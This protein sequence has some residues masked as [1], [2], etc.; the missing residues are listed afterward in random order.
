[1]CVTILLINHI[2]SGYLPADIFNF[3]SAKLIF[4]FIVIHFIYVNFNYSQRKINLKN[5]F[6]CYACNI[7]ELFVGRYN[8]FMLPRLLF[9]VKFQFV[10]HNLY[11][12]LAPI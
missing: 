1:M 4:T 12:H 3:L 2:I 6:E 5:I 7:G 9:M 8:F 10:W 11:V